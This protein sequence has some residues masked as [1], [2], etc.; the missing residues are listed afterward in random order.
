[1]TETDSRT[2]DRVDLV[3]F[4]CDGVLVDSERI[5]VRLHVALAA[6]FGW[7]LTEA[8]VVA[9]FVGRSTASIGEQVAERLGAAVAADWQRAFEERHR[10]AVDRELAPV[11]GIEAALAA[12]HRPSCVASS[13]SHEKMRHTLGRTGLYDYFDGRIFSATEVDRGKPAPDLF[14]HAAGRMGVPAAGCVVVEDSGPG[15]RAAR[16]AGMRVLGYAGGLTSA[17]SLAEAGAQQVFHEM[18]ELPGL[19]AALARGA[20][21]GAAAGTAGY[22]DEAAVLVEQYESVSFA[23]VHHGRLHLLPPAPAR[24][25]DLGAGSGR[26]AA[27]L[28]AL[29]HQ[30]TAVEPT[31][32]LRAAGER[33]HQ[34]AG[35]RWVDDALPGLPAL[36]AEGARFDLITVIAVW[37]HLAPAERATAMRTVA[38]LLGPGGMLLLTVRHGPVP[39]GRRMFTVR[40]EEVLDQARAAGLRAVHQDERGDLHGRG[41]VRWSEFGFTNDR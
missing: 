6:E 9:R 28:A 34:G 36:L 40:A 29:G 27:A 38:G 19:L 33:L 24:V 4:D 39:A 12:L 37:M 41:D 8:E 17:E 22:Q 32:A 21:R 23:Q 18:R 13:G 14:L 31:A 11:D 2:N 10:V 1:M 5:A 30:V 25:L 15:V 26:D 3:I 35:I 7:P 20:D 16:A